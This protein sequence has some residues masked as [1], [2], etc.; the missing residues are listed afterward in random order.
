MKHYVIDELRPKDYEQLKQYLDQI[1][2]ASGMEGLYWLP[3]G[4]DLL[5]DLQMD[6]SACRPFYIAVTLESDHISC[7]LLIRTRNK[8]QCDCMGYATEKQRNWIISWV[9]QAFIRL[10][11]HS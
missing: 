11:L 8:V 6:H 2:E 4:N 10:G 9:D 1:I 7:E 5:T 3:L